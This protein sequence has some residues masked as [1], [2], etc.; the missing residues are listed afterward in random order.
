MRYTKS[1]K[2]TTIKM[3][4]ITMPASTMKSLDPKAKVPV[5]GSPYN[6]YAYVLP[7]STKP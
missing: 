7:A 4:L 1:I 3:I 6:S 2:T 5:Y